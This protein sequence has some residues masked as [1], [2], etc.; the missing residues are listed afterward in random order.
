MSP[1]FVPLL[2]ECHFEHFLSVLDI[3][4]AFGIR[5]LPTQDIITTVIIYCFTHSVD[6]SII[7]FRTTIDGDIANGDNVVLVGAEEGNL[8]LT[9]PISDLKGKNNGA[10]AF[11]LLGT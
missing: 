11:T 7:F 3:H 5:H 8:V 2:F 9:P 10:S 4:S 1:F 6:A